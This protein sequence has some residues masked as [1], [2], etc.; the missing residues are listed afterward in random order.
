M[1]WTALQIGGAAQAT[2]ARDFAGRSPHV[3]GEAGRAPTAFHAAGV[4]STRRFKEDPIPTEEV[5]ASVRAGQPPGFRVRQAIAKFRT[6]CRRQP[7]S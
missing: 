1:A 7:V 3:A 5:K 2:P 4:I 6:A